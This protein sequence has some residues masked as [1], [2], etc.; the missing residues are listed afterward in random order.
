MHLK[1]QREGDIL[2]LSVDAGRVDAASAVF[3]KDQFRDAV[4]DHDGRVVI[5]LEKVDFMDSSGLG[6]M[7]AA[8]KIIADRALELANLSPTVLK[9]FRLTRMDKVFVLHDT[10]KDAL[11]RDLD[12][13]A[14]SSA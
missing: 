7:V 10:L 8:R 2:L 4:T 9:V 6:A 14:A 13:P 1:S 5:N 3:L 12:T 11:D